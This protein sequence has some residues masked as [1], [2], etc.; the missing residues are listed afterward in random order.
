MILITYHLCKLRVIVPISI[1]RH[2]VKV[3]LISTIL[4]KKKWR[5]CQ[6]GVYP[7]KYGHKIEHCFSRTARF[8]RHGWSP[9]MNSNGPARGVVVVVL[10]LTH[11]I[12]SVV[13]GQAP[14]TLELRNTPGKPHTQPKVVHAYITADASHASTRNI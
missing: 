3:T 13:T 9:Y 7:E 10:T 4:S 11:I 5:K 8:S 14:V 12:K 6:K 1:A 2:G